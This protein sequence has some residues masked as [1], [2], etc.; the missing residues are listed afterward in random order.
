MKYNW[1]SLFLRNF[2]IIL[3]IVFITLDFIDEEYIHSGLTGTKFLTTYIS[4]IILYV[5]YMTYR[6]FKKDGLRSIVDNISISFSFL[7]AMTIIFIPLFFLISFLLYKLPF[8]IRLIISFI[9]ACVGLISLIGFLF[10]L[11]LVISSR[12][13]YYIFGNT[14]FDKTLLDN[15]LDRNIITD[16]DYYIEEDKIIF[17]SKREEIQEYFTFLD[18]YLIKYGFQFETEIEE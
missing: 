6:K 5:I 18:K 7:L 1:K 12:L 3:S 17:V 16:N 8:I 13:Q 2:I 14:S 4:I 15:L 9:L 11:Y 10:V